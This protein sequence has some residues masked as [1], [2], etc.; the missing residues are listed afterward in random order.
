MSSYVTTIGTTDVSAPEFYIGSAKTETLLINEKPFS[1]SGPFGISGEYRTFKTK[2]LGGVSFGYIPRAELSVRAKVKET[3]T[4]TSQDLI[5]SF[6]YYDAGNNLHYLC[7][8]TVEVD[9]YL[10]DYTVDFQNCAS[11]PTNVK[12]FFYEFKKDADCLECDYLISKCAGG[13]YTKVKLDK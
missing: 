4:T 9:N 1:C 8:G 3:S 7:S 12:R 5:L 13:F 10:D 11:A 2:D 6:G